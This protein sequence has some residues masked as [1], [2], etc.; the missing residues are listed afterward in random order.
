MATKEREALSSVG[1]LATTV[2]IETHGELGEVEQVVARG[3][4]ENVWRR[5]K[6]DKVAIACWIF[7]VF[8]FIAAFGGAPLAAHILGHSPNDQFGN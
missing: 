7:I 4:W 2:A 6:R 1:G 8:L 5:F 3:Y